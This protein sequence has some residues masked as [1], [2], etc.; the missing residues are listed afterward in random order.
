MKT[1]EV[2]RGLETPFSS[3][4]FQSKFLIILDLKNL[5]IFKIIFTFSLISQSLIYGYIFS[6]YLDFF[7]NQ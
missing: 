2:T 1:S 6:L 5:L 4:S 7:N 3:Y